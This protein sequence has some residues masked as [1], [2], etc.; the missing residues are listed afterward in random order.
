M[1]TANENYR[2]LNE[3]CKRFKVKNVIITNKKSYINFKKINKNNLIK[4]FNSFQYLDKILKSKVD[5]T[6]SAIVGI[7]GLEPTIRIIKHTKKSL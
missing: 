4:V 6:M 1:L 2:E 5:Y 3:Q 7:H